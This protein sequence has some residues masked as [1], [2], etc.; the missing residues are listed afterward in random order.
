VG[1]RLGEEVITIR[2]DGYAPIG[3]YA[4]LGDGR[5]VA[6][7]AT[8]GCIDWYALPTLDA[9][10]AFAALLD[11]EHGG[12]FRLAPDGPYDV[13]R[14]YV[15]ETNVLETTF[16]TPQG[17]VRVT[18]ALTV[19]MA[20]PLPWA[21]L[22]RRV[23]CVDGSV[24]MQ[25]QVQPGTRFRQ[26]RPWAQQLD[27]VPIITIG[28]QQIAV[29]AFDIGEPQVQEH[30]VTG[31]AAMEAGDRGLLAI[32]SVDQEP[33][34]LPSRDE[35]ERR[36]DATVDS[37]R[38]WSREIDYD[39]PWRDA[40]VRSA[41]VLKTLIF[42]PTGAIAAA[43]TTSL[44]EAIGGERNW[45]YRYSW[46]RDSSF[47]I[48]A[49]MQLQ[50]HEE[51][52]KTL[53]W[54]LSTISRTA[55]DLHVFY[56][57]DGRLVEGESE[58]DL[59]GYR[60]SRP[61]RSGNGAARQ[62]QFGNF[63]DLL[64]SVWLYVQHG[65]RID[66]GTA[67]TLFRVADQVCDVWRHKDSGIWELGDHEDYTISKMA[68]WVALD[69]MVRLAECGQ[70]SPQHLHRWR[71]ERQDIKGW[72][73]QH[74]WSEAKRSYTFHAGTDDLDASVL[75]GGRTG[76]ADPKG[77]RF[78]STID[79][80]RSELSAGP[81][82]YRYSGMRQ[83]EGAFLACSFWLVHALTL[84]GRL[85][86]AR[87]LMDELVALGNDVGLYSEEMDPDTLEMLGNFPQGLTHLALVTAAAAYTD[88]VAGH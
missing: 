5:T 21:E 46:I 8:D 49:L 38:R 23:E 18:D 85:E 56:G 7:V 40:V 86:E 2:T 73:E 76:F 43:P 75:L 15:D 24:T 4:A 25:W 30:R 62:Q 55:P 63:G 83:K 79:A 44:P 20:G 14:R 60:H 87:A 67:D 70:V 22:V 11:P 33:L 88:A 51:V 69:R 9:P 6:L 1:T 26:A 34:R 72:V 42:S 82:L 19:G 3:S 45:D 80:I 57:L 54:L 78:N 48:D 71:I 32:S 10:P 47:T 41:L 58:L 12:R 27:G 64:E 59:P 13:S 29:R 61:V 31:V 28:D 16:R 74:C 17:T 68:C 36:V 66:E 65:N 39:G 35:V 52:H 77:E 84:A 50:L 81:L 37:W 53:S